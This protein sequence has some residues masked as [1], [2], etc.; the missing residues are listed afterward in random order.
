MGVLWVITFVIISYKK[1]K[2]GGG[3]KSEKKTGAAAGASKR[4]QVMAIG[5][6]KE[7]SIKPIKNEQSIKQK[8]ETMVTEDPD[9]KS[10]ETYDI[11]TQEEKQEIEKIKAQS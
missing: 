1:E 6:K 5:S 7:N 4:A 11:K 8:D 2:P 9:L 3:K 10:R